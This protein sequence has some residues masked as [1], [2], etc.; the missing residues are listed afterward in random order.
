LLAILVAGG[1]LGGCAL[2]ATPPRARLWTLFDFDRLARGAAGGGTDTDIAL[3]DGAGVPGG[4]PL[5]HFLG[6][7]SDGDELTLGTTF[8]EGYRSAYFTTELWS[9]FDQVWVQPAYLPVTASG[10]ALPPIFSVGPGSAFYSPYWQV[11]RFTVPDGTA[12]DAYTSVRDVIDSGLP[13]RRGEGQ[14]MTLAPDTVVLPAAP[15]RAIARPPLQKGWLDGQAI[16]FLNLGVGTFRWDADRVVAESPLFVFVMKNSDGQLAA[17]DVPSVGGPGPVFNEQLTIPIDGNKPL[18][19]TLWRV[20][21]VELPPTARAFAPPAYTDIEQKLAAKH[22]PTVGQY[23]DAYSMPADPMA[24]AQ[25]DPFIGRLALTPDCFADPMQITMDS[26][27]NWIDGERVIERMFDPALIKRT[28][29][30]ITC[31]FV[32]YKDAAVTP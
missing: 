8:T 21:T 5:S 13:L 30:L 32:S 26:A 25:F 28:G 14:L 9:G 10:A 19:G 7:T 2:P 6:T 15:T 12:A 22:L 24:F 18:Y 1:A 27:C 11:V 31:P 29:L 20:Y 16:S 3:A 17:L 23:A 4:V